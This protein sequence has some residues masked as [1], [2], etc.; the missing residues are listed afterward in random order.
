[1]EPLMLLPSSALHIKSFEVRNDKSHVVEA[2]TA[3]HLFVLCYVT[4]ADFFAISPPDTPCIFS[5]HS[6]SIPITDNTL[7]AH[8]GVITVPTFH[9]FAAARKIEGRR[10]G[11]RESVRRALG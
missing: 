3:T 10:S 8:V 2:A 1:M 6:V 9:P 7:Q 5:I 4:A 11:N